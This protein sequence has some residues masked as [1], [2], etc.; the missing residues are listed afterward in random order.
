MG[1]FFGNL[2]LQGGN[3]LL[4]GT[5]FGCLGLLSLALGLHPRVFDG[6]QYGRLF[7][8][9]TGHTVFFL[10]EA[11]CLHRC[12]LTHPGAPRQILQL[13]L[14]G[15][16]ARNRLHLAVDSG[17]KETFASGFEARHGA[18]MVLRAL[19]APGFGLGQKRI[20]SGKG[21]LNLG[22]LAT[23]LRVGEVEPLGPHLLQRESGAHAVGLGRR[24]LGLH[25]RPHGPGQGVV[26]DHLESSLALGGAT[27]DHLVVDAPCLSL[28]TDRDKLFIL[29]RDGHSRVKKRGLHHALD[30]GLAGHTDAH[31]AAG[32]AVQHPD[33]DGHGLGLSGL[34]HVLTRPRPRRSA[35]PQQPSPPNTCSHD[36]PVY[37]KNSP[38]TVSAAN[39]PT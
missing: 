8:G 24:Q 11:C 10:L 6:L 27:I 25:A 35:Q 19:C 14:N 26:A 20:A 1:F 4:Q 33:S 34:Q 2:R 17:R 29:R 5:L 7:G 36:S 30:I 13:P 18:G 12:H 28:P 23:G 15:R 3:F 38:L 16:F 9:F 21:P 31:I 22:V 32:F 37:R 39:R